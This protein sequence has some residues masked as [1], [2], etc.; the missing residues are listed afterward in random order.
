MICKSIKLLPREK[1]SVTDV[2]KGAAL[3]LRINYKENSESD[4]Q[5]KNTKCYSLI[6][7]A[8]FELD[9]IKFVYVICVFYEDVFGNKYV[10]IGINDESYHQPFSEMYKTININESL[11]F[12]YEEIKSVYQKETQ[13]IYE[14]Q[15]QHSN[16][17]TDNHGTSGA[18]GNS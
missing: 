4:W 14:A 7:N 8:R 15:E 9:W 1:W 16:T 18:S 13:R 10:T 3:N 17:E 5:K 12:D 2:G 6:P 11:F